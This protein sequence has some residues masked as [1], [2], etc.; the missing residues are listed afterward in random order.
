MDVKESAFRRAALLLSTIGATYAIVYNGKE[1][2]SGGTEFAMRRDGVLTGTLIPAKVKSLKPRADWTHTGYKEALTI[3]AA[4]DAWSYKCKSKAEA[5][6][7]QR[8]ATGEASRIWGS[9]NYISTV[10]DVC[11]FEILRL[12]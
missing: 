7:L 3:L 2:T 12:A 4:G 10:K 6:A 5:I 9:G 8:A 1:H 11:T